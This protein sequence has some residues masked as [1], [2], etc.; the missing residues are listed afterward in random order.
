[1]DS[2]IFVLTIVFV[3]YIVYWSIKNDNVRSISEQQGLLRMQNQEEPDKTS[4]TE[5]RPEGRK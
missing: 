2:L 4:S 3:G 1:M 5:A